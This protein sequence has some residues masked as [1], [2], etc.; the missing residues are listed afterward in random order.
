MRRDFN[1]E[2]NHETSRLLSELD[3]VI[4]QSG[5]MRDIVNRYERLRD[6]ETITGPSRKTRILRKE[7]RLM[8]IKLRLERAGHKLH[9]AELL[10]PA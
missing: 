8:E 1:I 3:L 7:I 10:S 9:S 5:V 4:N 6:L 2:A